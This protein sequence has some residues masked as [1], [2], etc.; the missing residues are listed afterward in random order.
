MSGVSREKLNILCSCFEYA[1]VRKTTTVWFRLILVIAIEDCNKFD[2]EW[3]TVFSSNRSSNRFVIKGWFSQFSLTY[4]NT[5]QPGADTMILIG[6]K[7]VKYVGRAIVI[8][9]PCFS[10][11]LKFILTKV[12]SDNTALENLNIFVIRKDI[13]CNPFA[14]AFGSRSIIIVLNVD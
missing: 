9:S 4:V 5:R 7:A 11:L 8:Q 12:N 1:V 2:K 14:F 6:N 3:T 10:L 13:N